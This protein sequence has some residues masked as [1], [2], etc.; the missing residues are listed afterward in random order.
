MITIDQSAIQPVQPSR[1][2][3]WTVFL[4]FLVALIG[5]AGL[6]TVVVVAWIAWSV[7]AGS[8][9]RQAATR[10]A[11]KSTTPA[12]FLVFAGCGQI[13]LAATVIAAA[14]RSAVPWRERLG[15]LP[16]QTPTRLYPLAM[17]GSL[18]PLAIG[19]ALAYLLLMFIP[20]DQQVEDLFNNMTPSLA[21]PFVLFI[22]LV[23]PVVEE[24][25]FRGYIQRRLLLR[26]KSGWALAMTSLLFAAMHV[27]PQAI[28][29]LFPLSLWWGVVAWRAGSIYPTMLCHAFVNGGLNVFRMVVKFGDLSE[30]TQVIANAIALSLSFL[31]FLLALR[32]L[33]RRS[34]ATRR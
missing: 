10:I 3:L 24:S 21:V 22:A 33:L 11:A 16:A 17:V 29:A 34:P 15:W 19:F 32:V 30:R 25:L 4:A 7:A 8:D 18:V 2:R 12:M 23:P 13:A 27:T 20:G 31:C 14:S 26:W 5:A 1:P 6:Q 28:V 9:V